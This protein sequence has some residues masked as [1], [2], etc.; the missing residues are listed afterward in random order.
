MLLFRVPESNR[1]MQDLRSRHFLGLHCVLQG[2]D[3]AHLFSAR[4]LKRQEPYWSF[5][6]PAYLCLRTEISS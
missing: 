5:L 1:P 6:C 2:K 3:R 4:Q